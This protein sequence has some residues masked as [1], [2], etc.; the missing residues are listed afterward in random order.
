MKK[1]ETII[2]KCKKEKQFC[3]DP[4]LPDDEE[5]TMYFTRG[6]VSWFKRD[7]TS[8]ELAGEATASMD[9][10]MATA[11]MGDTG[12]LGNTLSASVPLMKEDAADSFVAA[13][14]GGQEPSKE[15]KAKRKLGPLDPETGTDPEQIIDVMRDLMP[16][17][18]QEAA[19][20]HHYSISLQPHDI[21]DKLVEQMAKHAKW[22]NAAFR[23]VQKLV[24]AGVNKE[25]AYLKLKDEI[26]K[27]MSWFKTRAKTCAN[28][29]RD[30]VG[31]SGKKV[32]KKKKDGSNPDDA[33]AVA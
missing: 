33:K 29:E 18:S 30:L 12:I 25:S 15:Q 13:F 24:M 19:K 1:A 6:K 5:E 28:T 32:V 21:S 3:P 17:I 8:E 4:S 27:N 14:M 22:M 2:E 10:A 16:K 20:A 23:L 7:K 11:L 26:E 9:A 31:S